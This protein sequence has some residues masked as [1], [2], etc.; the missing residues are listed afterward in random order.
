MRNPLTSIFCHL[1]DKSAEKPLFASWQ[2][3]NVSIFIWMENCHNHGN[4]PGH[5]VVCE[6]VF[7]LFVSVAI[8]AGKII[9]SVG[10]LGK[11]KIVVLAIGVS[12]DTSQKK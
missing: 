12:H 1:I 11:T 10:M 6:S 8:L 9:I 4:D 5:L 2:I 7:G 3:C